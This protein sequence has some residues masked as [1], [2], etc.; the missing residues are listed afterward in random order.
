M[1]F[2]IGK[3]LA[4]FV[5]VMGVVSIGMGGI[6]IFQGIDKGNLIISSMCAENIEYGGADGEIVGIIDTPHEAQVMAGILREHRVERYGNYAQLERDDP[7]RQTILNAMTMENSLNLAQLGYGLSQVVLATGI[8]M[9]IVGITL[10]V[11]AVSI[12]SHR[13][14]TS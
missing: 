5:L 4:L 14:Q 12:L 8:F 10:G 2:T 3:K 6:F 11:G 1:A 7:N 9:L 13:K